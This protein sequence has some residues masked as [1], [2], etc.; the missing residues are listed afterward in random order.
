MS[1]VPQIRCRDLNEAPV[2]ADGEYILYWMVAFRRTQ[3]NFALDRAIEWSRALD[4]PLLVFEALRAGYQWASD[5]LHTFVIQGMA[6]QY[7]R[8]EARPGVRY[9]PYIEPEPGQGR[10]LLEALSERAAVV[11]TDDFPSFFVPRMQAAAADKLSVRLESIDSNGLLPIRAPKAIFAR[12][13]DFRRYLQ[14]NL[15]DHF[16][17]VP[18]I[19]PLANFRVDREVSLPRKLTSRWKPTR[20]DDLASPATLV[21]RLPIDHDVGAVSF[22]GGAKEARRKANTFVKQGLGAYGEGRNHPDQATSSGL[23]PWLH[24]GHISAHE[25]FKA[26]VDRE[27]WSPA[28]VA[29]KATGSREGWWGMSLGAESFLDEL[30]TWRELGFNMSSKRDDFT[31]YESLPD[32]ALRTL[33]EHA[34]DPRPHVYG[35]D[36]FEAARTHDEVWNAAQTELVRTG[37]MHNYLRMLWGKKILEWSPRPK[38]ALQVMEELNNKYAVDGR[39]PNSYSGIFWVLGRY[40]RAWGPER[41]IFGKIRY[42]SS[43]NTKKKIRMSRYLEEYGGRQASLL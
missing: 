21:S 6:E 1:R 35:L 29:P 8:L 10:G 32:W 22:C 36:E 43:D 26:L 15:P 33:A 25:V 16:A 17:D 23:S 7:R 24:F 14:K 5:R 27:G 40:D 42:M 4:K 39:N 11:V 31:R 19:D 28:A 20:L 13:H 38:D 9:F 2:N 12:A 37:R 34:D 30:M 18:V 41:P 3:Y